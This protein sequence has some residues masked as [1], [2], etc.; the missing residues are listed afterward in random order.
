MINE[1][2]IFSDELHNILDHGIT[3]RLFPGAAVLIK[4]PHHTAINV[5]RGNITYD[6]GSRS[7]N[8]DTL[9]DLASLTKV[10]T[11][12][13]VMQLDEIGLININDPISEYITEF[14]L[15]V[16]E[17]ITIWHIL[18]HSSGLDSIQKMEL[19]TIRDQDILFRRIFSEALKFKP[20]TNFLYTDLGFILL[21]R[22]IEVITGSTLDSYINQHIFMPLGMN[23]T[24]YTPKPQN[25]EN[26]APTEVDESGN[27]LKG[28]VHDEKARI[29]G[30]VAGHSGVFST[31]L[32]LEKFLSNFL[33]MIKSDKPS[34]IRPKTARMMVTPQIPEITSSQGLGWFINMP[35]MG[36]LAS[37]TTFG[38]TGYTGVS[39]LVDSEKEIVCIF[40]S[41][42]VHPKRP[43]DHNRKMLLQTREKIA[44]IALDYYS[45][46]RRFS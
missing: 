44:N 19:R 23:S 38:H 20:G 45:A 39:C 7:V 33:Y 21:G 17:Q 35:F 11:S 46:T 24:T 25:A 15:G 18:T 16:K 43:D 2:S 37:P 22:L 1:F 10:F 4:I 29:L 13:A 36:K 12:V 26:I 5:Y 8:A 27:C 3:K 30:G 34:I 9:Y 14:K 42:S 41:N 28:I 6:Q 32:D 31:A 40:L